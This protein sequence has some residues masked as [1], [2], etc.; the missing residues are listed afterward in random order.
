VTEAGTG[1]RLGG[2][3]VQAFCWQV[4]GSTQGQLCG[5]TQTASDGTY[6]VPLASGTYK[7]LFDHYPAHAAQY[8]GG[9]TELTSANSLEVVVPA[10]GS[11][12]GID[13]ALVPLRTV[14]GTVTGND[15][16]WAGST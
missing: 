9:G 1:A 3:S 12:T 13:A 6:S 2:V 11:V 15:A 5:Q 8:Y 16:P 14:T 4:V 7:V 10:N